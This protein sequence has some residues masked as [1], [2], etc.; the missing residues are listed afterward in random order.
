MNTH[1]AFVGKTTQPVYDGIRCYPSPGRLYL[2]ADDGVMDNAQG[3]QTKLKETNFE[4][5]RIKKITV[6]NRE[7]VDEIIEAIIQI[8]E[9]ESN[10]S[11]FINIT[12][13]LKFVNINS[14]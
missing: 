1:I 14:P 2:L 7:S 11:L 5:V 3:I 10:H 12:T 9:S 6:F 4:D 13:L 8:A